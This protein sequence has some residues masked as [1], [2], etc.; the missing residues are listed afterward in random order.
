MLV[1]IKLRF[2]STATLANQDI[3]IDNIRFQASVS[4]LTTSVENPTTATGLVS[5]K[6]K[7]EN[8]NLALRN[9]S[10]VKNRAIRIIAATT[11]PYMD[12]STVDTLSFK[13]D[14]E[15]GSVTDTG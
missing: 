7:Q 2:E 12:F 15:T 4:A 11:T 14:F 13:W 8:T 1:K 6:F 10:Y 9:A 3:I 5:I